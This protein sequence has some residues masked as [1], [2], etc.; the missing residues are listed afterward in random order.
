MPVVLIS[1]NMPHVFE[2]ADRINIHWAGQK[3][4]RRRSKGRFHVRCSRDYD[5][6]LANR[7]TQ[8]SI[9]VTTM[10]EPVGVLIGA[11][12]GTVVPSTG[13]FLKKLSE[14]AGIFADQAAFE[15]KVASENDPVVYESPLS[16]VQT[17][18]T[19]FLGTTVIMPSCVGDEFYMTRGH[20]HARRDM[21][22]IYY[23]QSGLGLLVMQSRDGATREVEM[24]PG[25]CVHIP[26]DW[27]HR[28]VNVGS[29]KLVFVWCCNQSAG[30]DYAEVRERGM[31]TR[32]LRT[33]EGYRTMRT[34]GG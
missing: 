14:L 20:F 6:C 13:R 25:V 21:G 31:L 5:R 11:D 28:S 15:A 12:D 19:I 2:V 16:I 4:Y 23:T 1:H 32:V 33:G 10:A 27:A 18:A 30:H 34:D 17:A 3:G 8:V 29:D 22:E 24:R 26:P 9:P 7:P